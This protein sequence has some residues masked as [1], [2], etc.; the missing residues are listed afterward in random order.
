M[1]EVVPSPMPGGNSFPGALHHTLRLIIHL[2]FIDYD[3]LTMLD[4]RPAIDDHHFD[5]S[6]VTIIDERFDGIMIWRRC[7]MVQ[8]DDENVRLGTRGQ[9]TEI[10]TPDK[11]AASN[12]G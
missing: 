4:Q 3:R 10:R 8:V 6:T 5:V 1:L 7:H 12:R 9:A 11:G 2:G